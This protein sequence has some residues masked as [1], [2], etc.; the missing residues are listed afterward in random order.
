MHENAAQPMYPC[1]RPG[2]LLLSDRTHSPH[3]AWAVLAARC[4]LTPSPWDLGAL[5]IHTQSAARRNNK[6]DQQHCQRSAPTS[7][8]C[9]TEAVECNSDTCVNARHRHATH[10]TQTKTRWE[11]KCVEARHRPPKH[12]TQKKEGGKAKLSK[13]G[14][15]QPSAIRT[16]RNVERQSCRNTAPTSF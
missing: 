16:R 8:A 3:I 13:Q 14:T 2:T 10:T 9:I 4:K 12:N 7:K 15:D 11:G 5:E 1:M 6:M